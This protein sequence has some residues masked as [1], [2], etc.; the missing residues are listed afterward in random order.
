MEDII[1]SIS[2]ISGHTYDEVY[3]LFFTQLRL[4]VIGVQSPNDVSPTNSPWAFLISNWFERNKEKKALSKILKERRQEEKALTL[5][6]LIMTRSQNYA[7][8]Y[9][10]IATVEITNRFFENK[11]VIQYNVSSNQSRTISFTLRK[12]QIPEVRQIINKVLAPKL[13]T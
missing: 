2:G 6:E 1:G 8:K 9:A 5:D 11:L 13:K 3:D 10:D 7:V 4:V 12:E